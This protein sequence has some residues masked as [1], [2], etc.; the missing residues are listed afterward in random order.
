MQRVFL[1][2]GVVLFIG[3]ALGLLRFT[4]GGPNAFGWSL[5]SAGFALSGGLC[6]LSAASVGSM[7]PHAL[8]E[9]RPRPRR[10]FGIS[11]IAAMA[12][13]ALAAVLFGWAATERQRRIVALT[14]EY[15][16]LAKRVGWSERMQKIGYVTR[17]QV[18]AD[19]ASFLEVKSTLERLGAAPPGR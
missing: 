5:L 15:Q 7:A 6:F 3:A 19:R 16:R 1:T 17:S 11:L 18:A 12:I 10:R 13:V 4:A 9:D 2:T 8:G 14:A